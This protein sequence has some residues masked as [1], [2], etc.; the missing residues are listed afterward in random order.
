MH[1]GRPVS[2]S[3]RH[4]RGLVDLQINGIGPVDFWTADA[5]G[6]RDAGRR[7]LASG[8]TSYLPTLTTAPLDRY[9]AGLERV[10]AARDAARA[11]GEPRI[12]GVHLEGP[13]LGAAPGAHPVDLLRPLDLPWLTG[14]LD[15]HPGLVRIVTLAPEADPGLDGTRAL[16]EHDVVVALGHSACD[17]DTAHAAAE[18]GARVVT[19]LFNGM[20][21]CTHRAPGLALAALDCPLLTPTLIADFVHVHPSVARAAAVS[22][23]C[24]LVTD[25]VAVGVE[26]FGQAVTARDGAAYLD[27]G[28]LTGSTLTMGV[29][30][31]NAAGLVGTERAWRMA[32]DIPAAVLGLH[33][34]DDRVALDPSSGE[35]AGVW[36]DGQRCYER[37][38]GTGAR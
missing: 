18:A 5:D 29:A 35:V 28:T 12:E 11:R 8:V 23:P 24:A 13:F 6:W 21:G 38:L 25:A 22:S 19:H 7:L 20:G 34:P 9:D 31:R 37:R 32:A 14:L 33:H 4:G 26:Y 1:A 10:A 15:R 30:L 27:D 36:I 2:G 3:V 16:V 17:Y